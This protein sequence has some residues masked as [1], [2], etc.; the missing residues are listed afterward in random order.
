M[1]NISSLEHA[2]DR[3]ENEKNIYRRLAFLTR[4]MTADHAFW[5]GNKRTAITIIT[6]EFSLNNIN[7]DK[8]KLVRTIVALADSGEGNVNIIE[9]RLRKCSK[10]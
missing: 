9:R 7:V 6:T 8:R 4:A 1:R 10:K 3:A 2:V 5:D